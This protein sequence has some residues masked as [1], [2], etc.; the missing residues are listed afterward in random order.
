MP[1]IKICGLMRREDIK[2][3]NQVLPDYIGFVFAPGRRQ[4]SREQAKLL[5][6]QLDSRIT[7]VGVF[8][9]EEERLMMEYLNANIIQAVQLHGQEE[10]AVVRRI[11]EE[12]GKAVIK[13]VSVK[14][15]EDIWKW[16]DSQADYLLFDHGAGGTGTSFC[17]DYLKEV[18]DLK[19]PFF[20]AGGIN[21]VN[22][23]D[24]LR[25]SPFCIDV[26]S[27]AETDG[28]K[29][30]VKINAFVTQVRASQ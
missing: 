23:E 25:L 19:K 1:K 27:G 14:T 26:S 13:A 8:V 22:L 2:A 24:A 16:Q 28:K 10:E 11:K 21:L 20:L 30:A 5:G 12:T 18:K 4:I 9:N 29:D 7:A 3:V 6:G 15:R 17:W